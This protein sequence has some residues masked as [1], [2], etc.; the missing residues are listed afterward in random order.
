MII[1]RCDECGFEANAIR[2]HLGV[3]DPPVGWIVVAEIDLSDPER[4]YCYKECE[5]EANT[6]A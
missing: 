4:H 3:D 2:G 6:Q 1:F 5:A